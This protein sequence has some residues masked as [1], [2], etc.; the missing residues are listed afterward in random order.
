MIIRTLVSFICIACFSQSVY[1]KKQVTIAGYGGN[2]VFAMKLLLEET[3]KDEFDKRNIDVS[4]FA[5]E[6]DYPKYVLNALSSGNAPDAFYVNTDVAQ[7]W[8]QTNQ[9]L[10]LPESLRS[11]RANITQ[12]VLENFTFNNS[13][14]AIPKD[15]NAIALVFNY[16]VFTDAGVTPPEN[17]DDWRDLKAKLEKVVEELGD[18]GVTGL[19]ISTDFNRFAPF[20]LATGWKPFDEQG[21]TILDE[22]FKRAFSFY[23]SLHSSGLAKMPSDLGQNW[24]G[25]CFAIERTAIAIEGSWIAGY[26][27][28]KSPNLLYGSTLLPKDPVSGERGN[29]LFSAGWAVNK[30]AEDVEATLEV[31]ELLTSNAAQSTILSSGLAIPS[32]TLLDDHPYYD[33]QEPKNQLAK[34]IQEGTQVNNTM[35]FSFGKYGNQWLEPIQIA[36]S[37]VMLGQLS[38][39]EALEEAQRAY[40]EMFK[41][42]GAN[43]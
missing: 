21:R 38:E 29:L 22:N 24:G 33:S 34:T 3:L 7:S 20:A 31:I 9:L 37:S 39:E 18:E 35:T 17:N 10:P 16:D 5:I 4:Y 12:K 14:F 23:L 19:C 40:D 42:V 11:A 13:L 25:G 6:S 26:L 15:M 30:N 8:I 27:R 2:D 41:K 36:L 28:D 1:A 32:S 43:K